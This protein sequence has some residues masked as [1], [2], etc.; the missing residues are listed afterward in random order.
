M[1]AILAVGFSCLLILPSFAAEIIEDFNDGEVILFSYPEEDQNPAAWQITATDTYDESAFALLIF[2]NT[3]KLETIEPTPLDTATVWQ[4]AAKVLSEAAEIQ[5]IALLDSLH[6][7][8]YAF[9]GS[10]AL[11]NDIWTTVYQGAFP[12]GDWQIYQLPVGADWLANFGYLPQIDHLAF[13]NDRDT[14]GVRFF[15]ID[16]IL[17]IT[18]DLPVAPQV[19]ILTDIGRPFRTPAGLRAVTVAFGAEVVDPDSDIHIY[20]W[21]FGD[22]TTSYETNPVHTFI[23]EDDHPYTVRLTVTDTTRK[24]GWATTQISVDTGETSFPVTFNFVGDI[25]LARRYEEE[26]GIIPTYG[27]EVIFEPTRDVL[28]RA[29]DVTVANLECP[30]TDRGTPHPSKSYV[31]RGSPA[32]VTALSYAGIDVV[33]LANNHAIDF[34]VEGQ[35]HT[36]ALLDS[37]GIAHSGG[38]DNAYQ[39]YQPL[40]YSEK[41]VN[42]AFLAFCDRTGQYDNLQPFLNAGFNKPGFAEET[43]YDVLRMIDAVRTDADAII[44][45]LHAGYEYAEHPEMAGESIIRGEAYRIQGSRDAANLRTPQPADRTLR[46][47]AI[48]AGAD[49][50]IC[51]HPHVLQGI[52]VYQ[53]KVIA[54]SLGNFAFDQNFPET[55]PSIILNAEYDQRGFYRWSITPIY[56]DDYIP[57]PATGELGLFILDHLAQ[58]SRD[59]GTILHVDREAGRG[60][61]VLDPATQETHSEMFT[62][63]L[64][65]QPA[66]SLRWQTVPIRLEREGFL[67][68]LYEIRP[69]PH[70]WRY[71]IGR[72]VLWMGNFEAEGSTLWELDHADESIDET[73]AHR[74]QRS[75]KQERPAGWVRLNTHLEKRLPIDATKPHTVQGWIKT[76]NAANATIHTRYYRWRTLGENLGTENIGTAIQGDADWTYLWHEMEIPPETIYLNVRLNSEG[77]ATGTGITWFDDISVIE[78]SEWQTVTQLPVDIPNPND[79]YYLQLETPVEPDSLIVRYIETIY[80]PEDPIISAGKPDHRPAVPQNVRLH[81]NYPNPFNPVTTLRYDLPEAGQVILKVYNIAGKLVTILVDEW[82]EKGTYQVQWNA[83]AHPS[84]VYL[85][86]LSWR[87][88]THTIHSV[89][90]K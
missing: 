55:F 35:R 13:F 17:D 25:M 20:H 88:T 43:V 67:S 15:F 83:R 7:L 86:R 12:V 21:D 60:Y 87:N 89:L 59:L 42:F 72:E 34:G 36:Q 56:I 84:G 19:T 82:Q 5:G 51:H 44:L 75:L 4:V 8:R 23:V 57:T 79:R 14:T 62:I 26:G 70:P 73:I 85:I 30:L 1:N 50:V 53:G 37:A 31:F 18:D 16:E 63:Q 77:P 76:E 78:W 29:A 61:V 27:A 68:Q 38:G 24:S 80:A 54:H 3:W 32:N 11:D 46:Q 9:S 65:L 40:F 2:G 22:S 39:A 81:Q 58:L 33:S 41:G 52:E 90:L 69:Q 48:D 6:E 71:R 64:A 10:E 49:A 45:E 28:G 66:D 74:G 47:M